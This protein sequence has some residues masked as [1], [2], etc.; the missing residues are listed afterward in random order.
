MSSDLVMRTKPRPLR[1]S[2]SDDLNNDRVVLDQ[3]PTEMQVRVI[4]KMFPNALNESFIF[5][6]SN[7]GFV[8]Q[9]V[10]RMSKNS[11]RTMPDQVLLCF[12]VLS[13]AR[14]PCPHTYSRENGRR[15]AIVH[16]CDAARAPSS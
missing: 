12:L 13:D 9:C 1:Y 11:L 15:M 5:S 7:D 3:I 2:T 14:P 10:L 8:A 16:P 6:G 4:H